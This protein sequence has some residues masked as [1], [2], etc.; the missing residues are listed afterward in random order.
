MKKT[1]FIAASLLFCLHSS[2]SAQFC[3]DTFNQVVVKII[4][5]GLWNLSDST[6]VT[7]LGNLS[8]GNPDIKY[9]SGLLI[10]SDGLIITNRRTV[11][12]ESGIEV[13]GLLVRLHK[14]NRYFPAKLVYMDP[15]YDLALIA[16][17]A[18]GLPFFNLTD[19]W[20]SGGLKGSIITILE[21][22]PQLFQKAPSVLSGSIG[23]QV[24]LNGS[25]V[26]QINAPAGPESYGAPVF[27]HEGKL[28]GMASAA[29]EKDQGTILVIPAIDMKGT[30][31]DMAIGGDLQLAR[32]AMEGDPWKL[33]EQ[34]SMLGIDIAKGEY[35]AMQASLQQLMAAPCPEACIL[36]SGFLYS[37][38]LADF[39]NKKNESG[40]LL[41][42]QAVNE[43]KKGVQLK[44]AL[45]ASRYAGYLLA[46]NDA[47]RNDR[48][49]MSPWRN[50]ISKVP[51]MNPATIPETGGT[52]K[53]GEKSL[54]LVPVVP[55]NSTAADEQGSGTSS[56]T[57]GLPDELGRKTLFRLSGSNTIGS[58]LAPALAEGFMRSRMS[59]AD[60]SVEPND[61]AI[62]K[63]VTG[64]AHH[65]T[66]LI[67][68]KA[69]GS[70]T[71]FKGLDSQT[72]DIGMSSRP[73]SSKELNSLKRL[74]DLTSAACEHVI[75][76]DGIAI[77]VNK[78]NP[79]NALS[80][81]DIAR[82]FSGE[83]TNWSAIDSA[84]KGS[85]TIYSRD[86]NSG[87]FDGLKRMVLERDPNAKK[88][89]SAS[90]VI[91][92][93]NDLI[94]EK[95]SRDINGIGFV[96]LPFIKNTKAL[97]IS[98]P[99]SSPLVPT[100]FT[101]QTEDYPL[102]R[103]LFLYVPTTV[104]SNYVNDF[105]SFAKSSEGQR[106]V[107]RIGFVSME[108]HSS[109]VALPTNPDR[110]YQ[111]ITRSAERLSLNFRFRVG[112]SDLDNKAVDDL[113][114][115]DLVPVGSPEERLSYL[116]AWLCRWNRNR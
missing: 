18:Q 70:A 6:Q 44:S 72:C 57:A 15:N 102:A 61:T 74:G 110:E 71:A 34:Y 77:I 26:L 35:P 11:T 16:I 37:S 67:A 89:L 90:S 103:R 107:E 87:T 80:V 59:A 23:R 40:T 65:D 95:V 54:A 1:M 75:G 47:G 5:T 19:D 48:A 114:R 30:V 104:S 4:G 92:E 66:L 85:I 78:G 69:H 41:L 8:K 32:K 33:H 63:I 82:I 60:V 42:N 84:M 116:S 109:K 56:V 111:K 62:E 98:E 9:G 97:G 79:I 28:V 81:P 51:G 86:S 52:G 39:K 24:E 64:I 43:V 10:G 2:I 36:H 31:N 38:A 73:V 101:V 115:F 45:G 94:S 50:S 14:S 68:I 22:S 93:G 106:I 25:T 58:E 91:C 99:G 7:P 46:L 13:P 76:L 53:P 105:L 108:I 49:A 100:V 83:I 21:Y 3:I 112:S 20:I 17:N 12:D 113:G 27:D 88:H 29:T 55:S 96:G